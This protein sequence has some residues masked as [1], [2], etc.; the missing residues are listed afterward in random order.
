MRVSQVQA[1]LVAADDAEIAADAEYERLCRQIGTIGYEG[2]LAAIGCPGHKL[3][4]PLV[5]S[6][7]A[8]PVVVVAPIAVAPVRRDSIL[9]RLA[10][11]F[12]LAA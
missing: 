2:Y 10:R 4:T 5:P 9:T 3:G 6:E 11:R 12:G 8:A 1:L 7:F